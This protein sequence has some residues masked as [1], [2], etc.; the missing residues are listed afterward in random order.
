M[1][2]N[3]Q[4]SVPDETEL[5]KNMFRDIKIRLG[6]KKKNTYRSTETQLNRLEVV[7]FFSQTS[8]RLD[9]VLDGYKNKKLTT[10]P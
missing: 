8:L 6:K 2:D 3:E 10:L 9:L 1:N 4:K 7:S 5:I